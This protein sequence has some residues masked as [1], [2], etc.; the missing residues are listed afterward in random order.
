MS[1]LVQ[2]DE[3][4]ERARSGAHRLLDNLVGLARQLCRSQQPEDDSFI[5]DDD[6]RIPAA[7]LDA[8]ADIAEAILHS[9]ERRVLARDVAGPLMRVLVPSVARPAA[10]QSS[11]P[12]TYSYTSPNPRL[13]SRHAA[14]DDMS[15]AES[16]Q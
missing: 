7:C 13:S 15:Q 12:S 10:I 16:Q 2:R 3:G 8:R 6:G 4:P 5:V 11:F 14:L 1:H 9:A